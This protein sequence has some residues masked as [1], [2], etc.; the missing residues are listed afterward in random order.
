MN[1]GFFVTNEPGETDAEHAARVKAKVQEVGMA[2]GVPD[3]TLGEAIS[4]TQSAIWE[5]AHGPRLHYTDF[6]RTIYTTKM[7]SATRYYDLCNEE[8][9]NG[10][11]NYTTSAYGQIKLDAQCDAYLNARIQAVYDYLMGLEPMEPVSRVVSSSSIISAATTKATANGDGTYDLAVKATVDVDMERGDTLTL[12]AVVDHTSYAHA[13]LRNGVQTVELT[14]EGVPADSAE[15]SVTLNIDGAQTVSDVVIY[16]AYGE[17]EAGQTMIGMYNARMPVH[18]AVRATTNRV[19]NFYKTTPVATGTDTVEYRPLEGITFDLYFVASI[20]D[21]LSGKVSLPKAEDY[22][23]PDMPSHEVITDAEGRATVNFTHHGLEDGVYLVVEREHPAIEKPVDPFYVTM[24]STNPDGTGYVYEITVQPK[25]DIKGGVEIEKDITAIGQN[26][27]TAHAYENHTW[28]IGTNIPEDIKGGKS[29][30]ITDTLDSRLDYAGNLKVNVETL[31]GTTVAAALTANTDYKLTVSDVDSLSQDKPS[32]SLTVELTQIGMGKIAAAIGDGSFAQYKLRVY[33]DAQI[34][35]NAQAGEN[36]PNRAT[37]H[38]T[39]SVNFDFDVE[40]DE[41][42]VYTG[43]TNLLKVDA[44]NHDR[45]LPGAVFEV[46]RKATA[47][48]VMGGADTLTH[49]SGVS[50]AVV[51]VSFF[52]NADLTGEKV[53]AV[54][55]D[56]QGAAAIYGLAY[57]T[58]YLLE[59]QAPEG[60][61]L[62]GDAV[63]LVIDA[64][65]HEAERTVTVKN[66]SGSPLPETGGMGTLPLTVTGLLLMA[67]CVVVLIMKKRE[68]RAA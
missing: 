42:V 21:Y 22:D 37:L 9:I 64:A 56:G 16:D 29:Y 35:A 20:S 62:I 43:G 57:G 40:S 18:A 19:L 55:S 46:Y 12:S 54:T 31:D 47:E 25:N 3:L 66:V 23:Y 27:D 61:N 59:T 24:P 49:I 60:Y 1:N 28:I 65:S 11:I 52:D 45:V 67:F 5:A 58:Y 8:R 48:E 44:A 30:V 33:F 50:A 36:I 13:A 41:P 51:K 53:T 68:G 38:Y 4:A 34:N 2:A 15:D 6:V 17:R 32:D 10:H 39:N 26:E 14:L 7:P 63:E